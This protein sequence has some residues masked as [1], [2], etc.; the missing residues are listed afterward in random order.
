MPA[1]WNLYFRENLNIGVSL[2]TLSRGDASKPSAD[3]EQDAALAAGQIYEKLTS[4]AYETKEIRR[5][6]I[7]G[8]VSKLL[9]GEGLTELQRKVLA[10]APFQEPKG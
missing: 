1:T 7:D 8:D 6:K 5:R 2:S 10:D 4:G 9:H 3:V